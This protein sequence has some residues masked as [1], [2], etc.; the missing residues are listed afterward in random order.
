MAEAGGGPPRHLIVSG[1]RAPSR[2]RGDEQVHL[3]DDDGIVAALKALGGTDSRLLD[4]EGIRS[5]ILPALRG[6]YRAIETYTYVPGPPLTCPI[7]AFIGDRD[8]RVTLDEAQAWQECT[9]GGFAVE[10]FPGDHFY[11]TARRAEVAGRL[12]ALLRAGR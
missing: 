12:S 9:A 7:T 1:R 8:P 4:D 11:L 6:D 3:R 2:R 5:M 10:I